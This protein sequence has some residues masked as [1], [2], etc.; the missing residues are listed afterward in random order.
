VVADQQWTTVQEEDHQNKE[1]LDLSGQILAL[2]K[3]VRAL[4]GPGG[5]TGQ[6]PASEKP[7]E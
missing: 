3:E 5:A 4:A 7:A 6:S 1:L 2:T